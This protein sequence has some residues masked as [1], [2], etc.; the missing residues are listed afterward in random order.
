VSDKVP[1]GW[2]AIELGDHVYIA[3]RIGWRGLK[4]QEYTASG[5]ILLS[6]PNL[7]HGDLVDFSKVFHVSR[8]RYE[9]S[10]EIQV[11]VGDTLLV[12]DGAGIGKLGYVSMVPG[13]TTV[14]SSLLVVRPDNDLLTNKYLFY[15][16]KGPQ[17][18]EIAL[19]R[20]T[21]SAT[22]HL[23][24]KD[25]KQ[26]RIMVPPVE[27]QLRIVSKLGKLLA[28]VGACKKRL[29]RI[30]V[31][32]RRFRQ[33]ILAAACCGRLTADWRNDDTADSDLPANWRSVPLEELLSPGGI[34]DGPF[35][36]NLK[37]SDYTNSG[38][39]VIRLENVGHLQFIN[40]K[41]TYIS[42]EK[43]LGL[44]RH[45]VRENDIIFASFIDESIRACVL[46]KMRTLAI[47]KADC[48]CL[49]PKI[50]V[51]RQYLTYQLVS[52][53]AYNHLFEHVH[54]A[55]RPRI[56]TSQLRKL[57][58]RICPVPEQQE[59]VRRV[60]ELFALADE[61]EGRYQKAKR[62][63][64]KLTQSILAKAFRGEL[65]PQDP[66]D[67]PAEKLLERIK[68]E[69]QNRKDGENPKLECRSPK[70]RK[71]LKRLA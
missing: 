16:L 6:V 59:I 22:P 67:E 11:R 61:I 55:T 17:F 32:L 29:E 68:I 47:A 52:R 23:F 35:G 49:R 31:L 62:H 64:D 56:N 36:S 71:P 42:N 13:P 51:N 20:I 41:E 38:V 7:N 39:R 50:T 25:I 24:Q 12:K 48:F 58:I 60:E 19:Q 63:V 1:R 43:Y 37:T 53:E 65:V 30:P 2:I 21:G 54:G 57:E 8:H 44:K 15:Y 3:G 34:F 9:E 46:P 18:Q 4:A 27:E 40:E 26:L 70:V 5:P 28:K 69:R 33:A 45:T 10:P 66:N 14:N